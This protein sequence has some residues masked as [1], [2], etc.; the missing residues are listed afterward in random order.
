[1]MFSL[2]SPILFDDDLDEIDADDFDIDFDEDFEFLCDEEFE[3]FINYDEY[4]SEESDVSGDG[5]CLDDDFDYFDSEE[6][7]PEDDVVAE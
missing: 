4:D 1:M 6:S 2:S 5:F 3:V 7:S